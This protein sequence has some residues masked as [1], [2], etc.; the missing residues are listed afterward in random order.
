MGPVALAVVAK[1]VGQAKVEIGAKAAGLILVLRPA[2]APALDLD[3]LLMAARLQ[4]MKR[5]A[6][7]GD[8]VVALLE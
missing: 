6:A 1:V 8:A 4:V 2:S 3:L 7:A 5:N